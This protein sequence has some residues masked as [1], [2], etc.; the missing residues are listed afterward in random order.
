MPIIIP[1]ARVKISNK[2][3]GIVAL[4]SKKETV[5]EVVF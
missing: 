3:R 5:T 1:I 2:A 4:K